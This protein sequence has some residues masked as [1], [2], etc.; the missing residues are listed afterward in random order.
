MACAACRDKACKSALGR[1]ISISTLSWRNKDCT[2]VCKSC[3]AVLCKRASAC[4]YRGQTGNAG[5]SAPS[6]TAPAPMTP[7]Q[8]RASMTAAMLGHRQR[9]QSYMQG[10]AG[11]S[12]PRNSVLRTCFWLAGCSAA[13]TL[14]RCCSVLDTTLHESSLQSSVDQQRAPGLACNT[15]SGSDQGQQEMTASCHSC[16]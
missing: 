4:L 15:L 5:D 7:R 9:R 14:I 16:T 3:V 13:C 12:A 10:S 11:N 6:H 2:R 8:R 1:V